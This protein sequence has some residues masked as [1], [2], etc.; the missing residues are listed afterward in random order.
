MAD[1]ATREA[2][3]SVKSQVVRAYV[4]RDAAALDRLYGEDYTAIGSDG[5][6]RTKTH[7]L[8]RVRTGEGDRLVEGRYDLVAVRRFGDLAVASGR[9]DL[10]YKAADGSTRK[11][12][13]NSV[14][15]FERRDGRWVY[16]AAYLP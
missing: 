16:V 8:A 6:V 4:D 2:L 14:N 9:G 10:T 5:S 11:A 13:Y 3:A 12:T 7:E 1:A 15:V